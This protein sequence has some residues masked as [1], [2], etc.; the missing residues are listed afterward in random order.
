MIENITKNTFEKEEDARKKKFIK[1][2]NDEAKKQGIKHR[3][4][5]HYGNHIHLYGGLIPF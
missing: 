1:S 3:L 2:F 4:C 5:F